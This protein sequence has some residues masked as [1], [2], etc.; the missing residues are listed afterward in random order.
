MAEGASRAKMAIQQRIWTVNQL[1]ECKVAV[2][3]LR[4][5]AA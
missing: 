2:E 5:G 3:M 1:S 4:V